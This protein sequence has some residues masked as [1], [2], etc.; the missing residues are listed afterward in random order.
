MGFS[1]N[2][3]W[4]V[5]G[6]IPF[7]LFS[8]CGDLEP[9]MQDTRSVVLKMNF[10]QRSSSRSS[11]ISLAEVSSHKTHLILALPS[12][13][14]L[15]SNYK[16]Y[17]NSRFA[18]ELMNPLD[19]KVSLKIPLNTQMKIFAFLFREDYTMP[20]LFSEVRE[21]GYYGESQQFSINAQTN[22]LSLGITLQS[23]GTTND[24][25][26]GTGTDTTP[27]APVISGISSGTYTTSQIFTVSGDSGATIQYSLDGGTTW[28]AYSA[29]VTLTNEGSYTITARQRSDAAG[30]WS[31]NATYIT[32]VI[33]QATDSTAPT[34]TFSPANGANGV[35]ISDNITITFSE[36]VRN[37]DDSVL[38]DS[39][40]GNLITLKLNSASGS[41][42]NFNATIN[43]EK[44]VITIDPVNDLPDSQTV[45][46]AIGATL[47]DSADN[48]ITAANA[49]F[50]TESLTDTTLLAHYAFEGN[51]NDNSSYNRHL[52]EAQGSQI[53]YSDINSQYNKSGQAALFNGTNTHAYTDNISIADTDN[54]TISFWTKPESS[55]M[56][57]WDSVMS[58]GDTTGGGR[59]QIDYS[60]YDKLRFNVSGT[61]IS[62]DLDADEWQHFVFTK[63]YFG[64]NYVSSYNHKL[65][66]YKDGDQ[67]ANRTQVSTHWDRLKIGLNRLGGSYWKGYIDDLRIYTRALTADEVEELFE[68]YE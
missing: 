20:Q 22:N 28:L 21:V 50:T 47:E 63:E 62:I 43:T 42:I 17:D 10:N 45:Y 34:V 46:V 66:Y 11:Q 37:I 67:L 51:L 2:L 16:N 32:V 39:D 60:G 5:F 1:R 3:L 61:S 14:P 13:E 65:T 54:W 38:T 25:D 31:V 35:A 58:T 7:F 30:N 49:S 41:N 52:T 24:S 15:S 53:T 29:A 36:S 4:L 44:T 40:L 56:S 9:E 23:A 6:M 55:N 26:P 64:A 27:A 48:P 19:N 57:Q 8:G 68:S 59:F 12:W 18:Q 33:N